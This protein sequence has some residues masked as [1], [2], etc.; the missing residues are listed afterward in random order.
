MSWPPDRD[1]APLARD[2]AKL[3]ADVQIR[4]DA[5]GA[6]DAKTTC[7]RRYKASSSI[8]TSDGFRDVESVY[9]PHGK[10]LARP[11]PSH[12][13]PSAIRQYN[14]CLSLSEFRLKIR[15]GK[16]RFDA[17]SGV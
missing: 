2:F 5:P 3:S 16:Y 1:Q 6:N 14:I 12:S 4:G 10:L 9:I 8:Q 17:P 11:H 13:N 15:F 7:T